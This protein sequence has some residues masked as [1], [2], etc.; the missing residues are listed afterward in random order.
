MS[1]ACAWHCIPSVGRD[2]SGQAYA[3]DTTWG[4]VRAKKRLSSLYTSTM[5]GRDTLRPGRWSGRQ[6]LVNGL[7]KGEDVARGLVV[8]RCEG[9]SLVAPL[10]CGEGGGRSLRG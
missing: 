1:L 7:R 5:V 2:V 3:W 6:R 9:V 4:R 8:Q 10:A